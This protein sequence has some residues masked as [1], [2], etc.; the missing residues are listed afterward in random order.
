[1]T[2]HIRLA[3]VCLA[4]SGLTLSEVRR[5]MAQSPTTQSPITQS[6][7]TQSPSSSHDE[8]L[9][10]NGQVTD[11]EGKPIVGAEVRLIAPM[12]F[13]GL[14]H[15]SFG[16]VAVQS[17][18][19]GEFALQVLADDSR[20][21]QG[22]Y[23]ETMLLVR[24]AG[25]E[26]HTTTFHLTRCLVDAPLSIKLR[27]A[28][29]L[30][31]HVVDASGNPL[32]KVTVRPAKIGEYFL[33]V[34][35]VTG[36]Q[37]ISDTA[38]IANFTGLPSG[39]LE[40][41]YL[42]S[43]EIGHQCV[44][45]SKTDAGLTAVA[46]TTQ[47]RRGRLTAPAN[48][49]YP[50]PDL[51][52]V[53]LQFISSL[54]E[55]RSAYTWSNSQV[56]SQGNFVVDHLGD[57][58]VTVR[59]QL[60][61]PMPYT[62]DSAVTY[63][64]LQLTDDGYQLELVPA[65][66][67]QGRIIDADSGEGLPQIHISTFDAGGRHCV[68]DD[69][70]NFFFW[71]G[72]GRVSYYPSHSLGLYNLDAAFYLSPQQIPEGGLLQLEPVQLKR[73]TSAV[74]RVVD[75]AENSLAGIEIQC[76]MKTERFTNTTTLWSDRHGQFRFFAV[77]NGETVSLTANSMATPSA[78]TQSPAIGT[79]RPMS[80]QLSDEAQPELILKSLPTA[81][82][83]GTVVDRSGT[84][85]ANATVVVRQA[86]VG[87]EEAY[88]GVDRSPEPLFR[89]DIV[90]TDL[91][92]RYQTPR[93]T[94]FKQDVSVSIKAA[95]YETF[96]SGWTKH[97]PSGS[98]GDQIELGQHSLLT[99]PASI[100]SRVT[101]H[102]AQTG[103]LLPNS[104]VVFLGAKSGQVK[105]VLKTGEATS[106][107]LKQSPQVIA[108]WA[109]GYQPLF[110]CV[111]HFE[112]DITG[113]FNIVFELGHEP[114]LDRVVATR[115]VE[116][117]R[118]AASELLASIPEP[119]LAASYHQ[120]IGYYS[121]ASFT[122]PS[123]VVDRIKLMKLAGA[124]LNILQGAMPILVRL[125]A[126]EIRRLLPLVSN[127][128]KMFLFTSM[129][130]QAT[131]DS[132][133]EELLGEALV[134]ARQLG[135]DEQLMAYANLSCTMLKYGMLDSALEVIGEA[136]DEHA[137]IREI[138]SQGQRLE[139]SSRKQGIARYFAPPLALL[140]RDEAFKLIELTAYTDE[141][142]WL[143]Y[144][145]ITFLAGEGQADWRAE[146]K[147]VGSS[148]LNGRGTEGYCDKVGFRNLER[149]LE[150]LN[151]LP[152]S[153]FK[154]K[155]CLHLADKST[156]TPQQKAEM[157]A[158][159]LPYLKLER[160]LGEDHPSQTAADACAKVAAWDPRLAEQFAFESLWLCEE[161]HTI[162]SFNL[163]GEL[164]MRLA[165]YDA[166]LARQLIIPCFE[167]WSWLFGGSD[168][169]VIYAHNQPLR[170][171]ACIDPSWCQELTADLLANEL[172]TQPS[173]KL[174]TLQA[175]IDVWSERAQRLGP[176]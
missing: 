170:A 107:K 24:A 8:P 160:E 137:E 23:C 172:A 121:C 118:S 4:F 88:A 30:P 68:T 7:I 71:A 47:S 175:V 155:F 174:T 164:A 54:D 79:L 176:H 6:P 96:N 45:L 14:S 46:L 59:G 105:Q 89:D 44:T 20:F 127:P 18:A 56:D 66:R 41:V 76:K 52:D 35:E 21:M 39:Q 131:T 151:C 159:G 60:P 142:D 82:F 145:A 86:I 65:T 84:S 102:D 37:A 1:M 157:A 109:E 140:H 132:Q 123:Q 17:G 74:G 168:Y 94:D 126:E 22:Y 12:N 13:R 16:S 33:P 114:N 42:I 9:R 43:Q 25:C 146:L 111:D 91:Q 166:Q 106:L 53:D 115:D 51:T 173:R 124:D 169:S 134:A 143:N 40:R 128:I 50:K 171:A 153:P 139:R 152:D 108:A 2:Y 141:I 90:T 150:L 80:L 147:R 36:S 27:L 69:D 130:E 116:Q 167:N 133:R 100:I 49:L 110:R 3:L 129:V 15:R 48:E 83:S 75:S 26:L 162:L 95:G 149:G 34:E 85:V 38:G 120:L 165:D 136:W 11:A 29:P 32:A 70:G 163:V 5:L 103:V 64:G 92:G 117:M 61:E 87:Q 161:D 73:M 113:N 77:T 148:R 55:K 93:T 97:K 158:Q 122:R 125:P 144:E 19:E 78:A 10:L 58:I 156:G 101:V 98:D 138:V 81:Y 31:I 72:P 104:R 62:L 112:P 119:L 67:V 99:E 154:A 63:S 57:G 28:T 135:G